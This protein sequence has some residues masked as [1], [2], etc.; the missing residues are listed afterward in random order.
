MAQTPDSPPSASRFGTFGGVF[1]PCT[2][3]ILGVIM[4]LRFGEV[5][6]NAGALHAVLIVLAA[7][8]ITVLTAFSLSAIA[9]NTPVKGGGAYFMISRSLGAAPGGAIGLVLY[10]A[11]S[12]SVAMYVIGFTEALVA[13]FPDLPGSFRALATLVNLTVLVCV[14]IGAGWT[15]RLQYGILALL[16]LS[17]VS[18]M[19]GAVRLWS[20]DV[21]MANFN[22]AYADGT[23]AR[24]MFALFFPAVTGIM[25]GANMSGDLKNPAKAIPRGT[26]WAIGVTGAIYLALAAT[27][28]GLAD[29]ARLRA[30]RMLMH[31]VAWM[32]VL[33]TGGIFAATLSSALGS[34]MGAPRVLQALS[35]DQ[36]FRPLRPFGHGS[37]VN[38]EPRRAV[39]ATALIAQGAIL[40]GDLNAIAPVITMFFIITYGMLNLACFAEM[41]SRNPSFRPS[42]RIFHKTIPLTGALGCIAVML[43]VNPLWA[44]ASILV[45]GLIF[46]LLQRKDLETRWGDVNSGVAFERAK[47]TLLYLEYGRYHP[48]NWRPAI[49]VFTGN[50][51]HRLHLAR[52]GTWLTDR[53]LLTLA[54]VIHGG[55]GEG[56]GEQVRQEDEL[57]AFI[58]EN[59]LAAFPAVVSAN[60]F[61]QGAQSLVQCHG[62]GPLRSNTVMLGWSDAP[63]RQEEFGRLLRMIQELKRSMLVVRMRDEIEEEVS[64]AEGPIDVW[65]RG[66]DHGALMLLLAHLLSQTPEWNNRRIRLL[67][68]VPDE[69]R[70]EPARRKLETLIRD[71]RIAAEPVVVRSTSFADALY[72]QSGASSLVFLGFR[73]PDKGEER[74]FMKRF[75]ALMKG[76]PDVILVHSE[77]SAKLEA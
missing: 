8:A 5:V 41:H 3:T 66:R 39:L 40:L 68:A 67:R 12:V 62:I 18:F 19:A 46:F 76:L 23:D 35:I 43:L 15:I 63:E 70:V 45:M 29:P 37:G 54:R 32:P 20:P 59:R 47:R 50:P 13:T 38:R 16:A 58:R 36:V 48:K 71:A 69:D 72:A 77:G 65:W 17:L 34:M 52:L 51:H 75:R 10:L 22:P 73:T 64:P 53:G 7:K 21:F 26:L 24:I 55:V 6:G 61:L 27:L 57:R 11:Q 4:F 42:F 25:A 31:D 74:A 28:A 1:T 9:T 49:M 60:S 56:A 44:L 30:D 2:L 33:V 14:Y